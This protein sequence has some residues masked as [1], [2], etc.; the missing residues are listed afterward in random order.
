MVLAFIPELWR[1]WFIKEVPSFSLFFSIWYYREHK[2]KEVYSA[3]RI[4]SLM[5]RGSF[6]HST[7]TSQP[8]SWATSSPFSH[9]DSNPSGALSGKKHRSVSSTQHPAQTAGI[10]PPPA[11]HVW[12]RILLCNFFLTATKYSIQNTAWIR[13][14]RE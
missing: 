5:K 7:A 12:R 11:A 10:S 9:R 3:R 4:L 14:T 6:I 13:D 2:T 8:R 1:W